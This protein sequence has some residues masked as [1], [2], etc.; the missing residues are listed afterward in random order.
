MKF[1]KIITILILIISCRQENKKIIILSK[2]ATDFIINE[3]YDKA[4]DAY[5][6]IIKIDKNNYHAFEGKSTIFIIKK[7]YKNAE[8]QIDSALEIKS[9]Y[10]E[11]YFLKGLLN[12]KMNN[13]TKAIK[14]FEK[15]IELYKQ[16]KTDLKWDEK[17]R[18][19]NIYYSYYFI[20][21]DYSKSEMKKI[22]EKYKNDIKVIEYFKLIRGHS[23]EETINTLL[24]E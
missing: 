9:D 2:T 4:M 12:L 5:N 14:Y 18:D 16:R 15:S 6:K 7:D 8:I 21:N 10:A 22:E 24:P 13:K 23:K 1:F 3:D 19:I 11:A 20:D 17:S